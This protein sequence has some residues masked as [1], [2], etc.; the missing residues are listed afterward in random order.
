M[1]LG[2]IVNSKEEVLKILANGHVLIN[3]ILKKIENLTEIDLAVVWAAFPDL[4]NEIA[5]DPTS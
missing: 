4:L 1:K 2:T 3:K 5:C